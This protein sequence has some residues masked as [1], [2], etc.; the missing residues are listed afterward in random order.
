MNFLSFVKKPFTKKHRLPWYKRAWIK[1]KNQAK[2]GPLFNIGAL[3][4][5]LWSASFVFVLLWGLNVSL[6]SENEMNTTNAH[7][8]TRTFSFV[9]YIN[10]F[11]TL[12]FNNTNYWGML[13]NS[14]W[15][16]TGATIM[17]LISTV[18]FA[19][20]IARFSFPGRKFLYLFVLVQMMLPTYGQTA[21]NY[22]LLSSI[23]LVDSPLFLLAMGAGHGMF[24][25]ICHSF[26]ETLPKDYEESARIDGCGYFRTFFSVMLPLAAPILVCIGLMTFISCWNDYATTL[27][28]LP[29][30]RTLTSALYSYSEITMHSSS[31]SLPVY[32]AG[33]FMSALP[34]VILYIRFNKTLMSNMTI[35]GIKG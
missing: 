21:A 23:G 32:F 30:W 18:F 11:K 25:M 34:I 5:L 33:V 20:V 4:V 1:I 29:H 13:W 2:E 14:I 9:N 31:G 24:F 27:L 28:Y 8:F 19:Y 7:F 3:I 35:G 12:N 17:K 6:M 22:Q 16:S 15:F 26:F 10:A